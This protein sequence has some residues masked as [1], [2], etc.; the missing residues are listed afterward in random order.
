MRDNS[1]IM[2]DWAEFFARQTPPGNLKEVR[3]TVS[4]FAGTQRAAGRD[5]VFVTVSCQ[6]RIYYRHFLKESVSPE[7]YAH[8]LRNLAITIKTCKEQYILWLNEATEMQ[9]KSKKC[10]RLVYGSQ[11]LDLMI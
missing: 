5:I 6:I 4:E 2:A 7:I 9:S 1:W 11:I 10:I 3:A 8:T